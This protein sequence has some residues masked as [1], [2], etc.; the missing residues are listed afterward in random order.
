KVAIISQSLAH[1]Y[2][3]GENPIGKKIEFGFPPDS[4][5]TREIV[6]VVGNVRDAGLAQEPGPM[7]YV[8]FSQAPFW[9]GGLVV[10]TTLAPAT[11]KEEVR[12]VV[13]GIDGNLPLTDVAKMS[14]VLEASVAQP[15]FRTWL[16]SAFGAVALLLAAAGVF[17]VVSYSVASRTREFGV[18]ASLGA[19]PGDLSKMVLREGLVLACSGLA[20]GLAAAL[21]L[22]RFLKG[23]LYGVAAYDPVTL[24]VSIVVL[25]AI[26]L[27][28]CYLPARRAMRVD[29]VVALRHE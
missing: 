5:V 7:M 6:G 11:A 8:P 15:R 26:A 18:R 23:Q 10:K 4:N 12:Q 24:V 14:D 28:A 27:F 2:F 22:T 19:T 1:I 17:G 25:L 29:P 21:G 20:V 3:P 13:R 16:L 9:G